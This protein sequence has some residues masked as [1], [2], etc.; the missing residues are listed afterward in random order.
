MELWKWIAGAV[1]IGAAGYAAK[2]QLDKTPRFGDVAEVPFNN[3][4]AVGLPGL[5]LQGQS[6]A[7]NPGII[8]TIAGLPFQGLASNP[9]SGTAIVGSVSVPVQFLRNDIVHLTRAGKQIF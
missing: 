5:P 6:G 7:I 4:K 3:L 1:G 9:Y 2:T 8:V